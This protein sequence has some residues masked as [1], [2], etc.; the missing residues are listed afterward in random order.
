VPVLLAAFVLIIAARTNSGS[1][2]D[3]TAYRDAMLAP[4]IVASAIALPLGL[5]VL[6]IAARGRRTLDRLRIQEVSEQWPDPVLRAQIE[7]AG[8]LSEFTDGAVWVVWGADLVVI[9][10]WVWMVVLLVNAA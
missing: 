8:R 1:L 2:T 5:V 10:F 6:L 4:M 7:A 3:V 9:A